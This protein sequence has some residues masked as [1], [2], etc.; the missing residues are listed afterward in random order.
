MF[1]SKYIWI[2][3]LVPV[4]ILLVALNWSETYQKDINKKCLKMYGE[5]AMVGEAE[6]VGQVGEFYFVSKEKDT[7]GCIVLAKA[8]GKYDNFDFMISYDQNAVIKDIEVL[9]YRE[10]FGFE[11]S[12]KRW[13]RQ[14][15]GLGREDIVFHDDVQAI[16]G[17][18]LS[19]RSITVKIDEITNEM[20]KRLE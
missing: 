14:F 11:I 19:C 17:A 18:T 5:T 2:A 15:I 6:A 20:R 9:V 10:D 16:S 1:G 8:F 12:S 3:I 7:M 13:L 4:W